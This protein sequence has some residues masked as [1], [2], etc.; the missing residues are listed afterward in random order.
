MEADTCQSGA[1]LGP[2]LIQDILPLLGGNHCS[3]GLIFVSGGMHRASEGRTTVHTGIDLMLALDNDLSDG[4]LGCH[5]G[6]KEA[7]SV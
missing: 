2:D 3:C 4:V 5:D 1:Q 7:G 6:A